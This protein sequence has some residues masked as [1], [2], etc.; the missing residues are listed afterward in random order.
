MKDRAIS[1]HARVRCPCGEIHRLEELRSVR[2]SPFGSEIDRWDFMCPT[3]HTVLVYGAITFGLY[4]KSDVEVIEE[5]YT[6]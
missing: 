6:H 5:F 1:P 3:T 2:L 4:A